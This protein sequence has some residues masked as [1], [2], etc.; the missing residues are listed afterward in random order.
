MQLAHPS[1]NGVGRLSKSYHFHPSHFSGSMFFGSPL[2][3]SASRATS[4]KC[5]LSNFEFKRRRNLM[6]LMLNPVSSCASLLAQ[7]SKDSSHSSFPPG[8]ANFP[9]PW[10]FLRLPS[11]AFPSFKITTVTPGFGCF[12]LFSMGLFKPQYHSA[13]AGATGF[14]FACFFRRFFHGS[15]CT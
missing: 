14:R 2:S 7:P 4:T 10:E 5:L 3:Q 8:K 13:V 9:A 12:N 6:F 15:A 1:K 11:S